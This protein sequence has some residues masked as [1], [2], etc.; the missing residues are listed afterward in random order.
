M[1][2][3]GSFTVLIWQHS[4]K[5]FQRLLRIPRASHCEETFLATVVYMSVICFDSQL[6]NN[7]NK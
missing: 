2:I 3:T 1:L 4:C 5:R 6:G 7:A